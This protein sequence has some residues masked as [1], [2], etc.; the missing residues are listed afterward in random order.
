M[1]EPNLTINMMTADLTPG[2]AIGNYLLTSAKIWQ[3]WGAKVHIYADNI[4][5]AYGGLA[6]PS[7]WYEPDGRSLLWYHYSIFAPNLELALNS[8]DYRVFDFH[9]VAPS[10]LFAGQNSHLQSLCEKGQAILPSLRDQFDLCIVHSDYSR[11]ELMRHGFKP[12]IIHKLP[13]IVDT[14]RLFTNG[15]DPLT[16]LLSKLEYILFVGR[17]I[18]Q[19]DILAMLNIFTHIHE[20][21]SDVVLILA[22]T[23]H[24]AKNYQ[25]QID[26]VI[27][28][29]KI[30]HRVLIT[31]QINDPST[32]SSLFDNAAMLLVTSE[33]ESFCVPVVE[34]MYFGTPVVVHDIPPLPEVA[35]NGGIVIEKRR[36]QDAAKAI[37]S[38]WQDYDRYQMLRHMARERSAN[39]TDD[40][41]AAELLRLLHDNFISI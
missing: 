25:R 24:L 26:R 20:E 30:E 40:T 38:L 39:F 13:L 10:S 19:K 15:N 23:R 22:G 17:L 12:G 8:H 37:L 36:P 4:S 16:P 35:G 41:L 3:S 9:G 31:G 2:D 11:A 34:A 7:S 18:P 14:S 1:S 33:W 27:A 21:R 6:R 28:Q 32:L 29:K 5:P